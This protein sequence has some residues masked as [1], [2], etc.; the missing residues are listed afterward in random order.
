ME[1]QRRL[2]AGK[3]NSKEENE[4]KEFFKDMQT[5]LKPIKVRNPYA[6]LLKLPEYIF[7]PLRTNSHYLATIETITFYHQYQREIKTDKLTG[8]R[9][10]E[11]TLEDIEWAN[12]LLKDVLLA[13]S[14]E[15]PR[16]V[17]EFFESLKRWIKKE[18]LPAGKAGKENFFAKEVREAF[19]MYPMKVNRYMYE[20]ESR[21]FIRKTGGNRKTGFEY[22]IYRWD[23]Y[24]KLQ[25]GTDV[26]NEVL[27]QIRSK[28]RSVTVA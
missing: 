28:T 25:A 6:E 26:M 2:S 14:D 24:E 19:R 17:R 12:I 27:E 1:Y 9:Y 11:T 15:L 13:K 4:L 16:A 18:N 7:K 22:E 5:V 21:G 20:L 10:I 8:E 23:D 3:V